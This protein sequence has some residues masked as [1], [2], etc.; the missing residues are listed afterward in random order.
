MTARLKALCAL[1]DPCE[2]FIDVGCDHGYVVQFVWERQIAP[3]ITACDISRPSLEKARKRL[4]ECANVTFVCDD[5]ARAAAGHHTV[6][7]AGLGGAEICSVM[8]GCSP[9][10]F[11][12]S[13]QSQADAVRQALLTRDYA[14]V[15]D[16][17]VQD[18][19]KFY[20]VIKA[21]RGGGHAQGA[22]TSVLQLRFGMFL[23]EKNAAL[24]EKLRAREKALRSYPSTEE[25][26]RKLSEIE[27]AILW[28]L[29]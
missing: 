20:D 15:Y 2:S 19:G 25:N 17:V 10:T 23:Q 8:S 27:E 22:E 6:M 14:I 12:L 29:R 11:I 13:P 28:Q 9:Q 24:Y 21:T 26:A 3:R 1:I 18:G 4:G 16:R 7:V 5:G